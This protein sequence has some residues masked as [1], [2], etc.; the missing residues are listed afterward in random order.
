MT[1]HINTHDEDFKKIVQD[2]GIPTTAEEMQ[3]KWDKIN[4]DQ[5]SLIKNDS[6]WSPF[7]K[8]ISAIITSPAQW[9]V[10]FLINQ[11]LPNNYVKTAGKPWLDIIAWGL[12]LSRKDAGNAQGNITFTRENLETPVEVPAGTL[13]HSTPIN[14]K[15]YEVLV[16]A[17]TPFTDGEITADIACQAAE[18][19]DSYN[20]APGYYQILPVDVP[21]VVSVRNNTDW[22]T[23][24]GANQEENDELRLR[25]RNQFTAVGLF[26]HDAAYK[27][28]ISEFA[29]IRTDFLY[30]EH[31]A[32]RGPG[33]ANCYIM[34]D[35][36][37]PPDD[38]VDDINQHISENGYHGHGDSMIC[39]PIPALPVDVKL[40]VWFV[41]NLSADERS[42]KL[43]NIENMVRCAF[44]Q[45]TDY[46]NVVTQTWAQSLFSFSRLTE[47]LHQNFAGIKTLE[48]DNTD[49]RTEL[50]LATLESLSL[51]T[52]VAAYV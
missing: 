17:D 4:E 35:S 39:Y 18:A 5:N 40:K 6:A 30:F 9:V 23:K 14:N 31:D 8:L 37:I 15:I 48:F 49:I 13:V 27:Q 29:G 20:L 22:L 45:N 46:Q 2:A 12:D 25:C 7:W 51:T 1:D 47:E 3:A 19:G 26:H 41:A 43:K 24:P 10:N 28:I 38:F 21:G 16:M 36:G 50:E 32:P 42:E 33:T 11:L 44:R 34:I 52:E